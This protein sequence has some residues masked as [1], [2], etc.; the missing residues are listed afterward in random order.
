MCL[1]RHIDFHAQVFAWREELKWNGS[2]S[3]HTEVDRTVGQK[4]DKHTA[5]AAIV[6]WAGHCL[7]PLRAG[8]KLELN[9]VLDTAKPEEELDEE[10]K[11]Q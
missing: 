1:F 10:R 5:V 9:R 11:G 7:R 8:V 2:T 3:I 6:S 4:S